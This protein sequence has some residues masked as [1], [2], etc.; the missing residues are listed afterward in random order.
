MS[1]SILDFSLFSPLGEGKA[2]HAEA[3]RT[4]RIPADFSVHRDEATLLRDLWEPLRRHIVG[5]PS[6]RVGV[7]VSNSKYNFK[8]QGP[9]PW[10][11]SA[12]GEGNESTD[13]VGRERGEALNFLS[14]SLSSILAAWIGPC[15]IPYN[16]TAACV[17]GLVSVLT[18]VDWLRRGWVDVVIAGSLETS[19]VPLIEAAFSQMGVLSKQGACR[20]FSQDR[21]GFVIGE[22]GALFVLKRSEESSAAVTAVA[23][24]ENGTLMADP[25]DMLSLDPTGASIARL[26]KNTIGTSRIDYVNAHGTGTRPND[27]AELAAFKQVFKEHKPLISSTKSQTGHLLGAT[28]AVELALCLLML[29]ANTAVPLLSEN[30]MPDILPFQEIPQNLNRILTL[31]YGFGGHLAALMIARP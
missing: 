12:S 28:G 18:G 17:T 25:T 5:I 15:A 3:L 6:N 14:H 4:K 26:I 9:H 11:L 1:V 22:G 10:P 8:I 7:V 29:S 16:V 30:P 2:V 20:P 19:K 13:I 31:N 27:S 24:I 23:K 21:D